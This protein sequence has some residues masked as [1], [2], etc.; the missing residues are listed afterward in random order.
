MKISAFVPFGA[1]SQESG[2]IYLLANYLKVTFPE[3]VQL[4]CNGVF[5]LCDRDAENSWNRNINS[6]FQ[7]MADQKSMS[8]WSALPVQ[9]LSAYLTPEDISETKK[10]ILRMPSKDLKVAIFL[11]HNLFELCKDSFAERFRQSE[12]DYDNKSH[13]QFVKKLMLSAARMLLATRHY[14][15]RFAP[16]LTIVAN[17][18]DF[19]TRCYFEQSRRMQR[20]VAVFR[21]ELAQRSVQIIRPRD[22][23]ILSSELV[24]ENILA[25]RSDVRTWPFELSGIMSEIAKFLEIDASQIRLPLA[26]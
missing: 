23:A 2:L 4:R 9:S 26:Q 12:L 13:E 6:C 19:L 22:N 10:M 17:G 7:C 3:V 21:W 15:Q 1:Q 14:Q 5:S 20:A 18:S 25:M 11:D 8:D 24:P 16:D